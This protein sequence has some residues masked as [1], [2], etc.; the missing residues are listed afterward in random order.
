[1]KT[2]QLIELSCAE[3]HRI[4]YVKPS[5]QWTNKHYGVEQRKVCSV[6]CQKAYQKKFWN[7]DVERQNRSNRQKGDK[8]SNW[9]GGVLYYEGYAGVYYC[10]EH[11]HKLQSNH[12]PRAILVMEE[13]LGR[14]LRKEEVVYHINRNRADDRIEN[15]MLFED[16]SVHMRF[17]CLSGMLTGRKNTD[18]Q[19]QR[20]RDAQLNRIRN[21]TT[22]NE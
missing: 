19:K 5:R 3:C 2:Q 7:S 17:H 11:I 21:R 10:W 1:M 16:S 4:Y 9:K 18:E 14:R 12:V 8:N 22:Q 13:F 6:V 20:M 15:L